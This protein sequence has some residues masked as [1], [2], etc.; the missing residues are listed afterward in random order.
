[1]LTIPS[2]SLN[3]AF[4]STV[5]SRWPSLPPCHMQSQ[6]SHTY[7]IRGNCLRY[8]LMA[9]SWMPFGSGGARRGSTVPSVSQRW[10]TVANSSTYLPRHASSK[11]ISFSTIQSRVAGSARSDWS[12]GSVV[13]LVARSLSAS[14]K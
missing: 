6:S 13:A 14:T 9:A 5:I 7:L 2:I 10:L 11:F 8:F 12:A 4:S 1:M 3:P